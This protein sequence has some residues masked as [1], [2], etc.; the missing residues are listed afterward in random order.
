MIYPNALS[1]N[2]NA[3][4]YLYLQG[5]PSVCGCAA[6]C[7]CGVPTVPKIAPQY[8][9]PAEAVSY[10]SVAELNEFCQD[11]NYIQE[12][13]SIPILPL[14]FT[15]FCIP[16]SPLCVMSH[17]ETRRTK[18]LE[19]L[20]EK[21]N[22]EKFVSRGCH[23]ERVAYPYT[24]RHRHA[25]VSIPMLALI[26]HNNNA[27]SGNV[28]AEVAALRTTSYP[29]AQVQVGPAAPT[30]VSLQ[31]MYRNDNTGVASTVSYTPSAPPTQTEPHPSS[32]F[33]MFSMSK[34]QPRN[35]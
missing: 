33:N 14:I 34:V 19:Q 32:S 3:V 5:G 12:H 30:T 28:A 1:P 35:Y 25:V 17:Y 9:V 20:L 23:W 31:P 16:F 26:K 29:S 22:T 27:S 4:I 8:A 6:D 7:G 18:K 15:H 2:P 10:I 24:G 13:N 11:V 21:V